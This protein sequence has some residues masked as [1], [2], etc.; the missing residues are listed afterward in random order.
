MSK[1]DVDLQQ[2]LKREWPWKL[3]LASTRPLN[4]FSSMVASKSNIS[5]KLQA[6]KAVVAS[7]S[8][9]ASVELKANETQIKE[10][11]PKRDQLTNAKDFL[12]QAFAKN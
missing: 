12:Q 5:M 2:S 11:H 9:K 10:L 4:Y 7:F 8:D 6:K 1:E 3:C